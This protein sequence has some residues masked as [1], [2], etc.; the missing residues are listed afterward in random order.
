MPEPLEERAL[1]DRG[2]RLNSTGADREEWRSNGQ[3][4]VDRISYSTEF[5]RLAGVTQVIP[6]QQDHLYHDR[7]THSIK[8]AQVAATLARRLHH[9][10]KKLE[11][12]DSLSSWVDADHC[13]AAGLAHDIGH[14]PFGHAGENAL[15]QL[16]GELTGDA[17][18]EA[19]SRRSFEGNA[20]SMRI[21]ASLSFR[22]DE[23]QAGLD[24]TLRSLAAVA[25]YP[26]LRGGHPSAIP[27][28]AE[29]WSFYPEEAHVLERL[30]TDGYI[31]VEMGSPISGRK[32]A[33]IL[34][35][36]RWP[37]AEIM[38]WADDISYAVH[39]LE[40]FFRAGQI[41][42]HR[43]AAALK[44]A[45][46]H[47]DWTQTDFSFAGNDEEVAQALRFVRHK[48]SKV[49]VGS[50]AGSS[51]EFVAPAFN[52]IRQSLA[53]HFPLT[54]FDGTRR[55]QASVQKF[56]STIITYLTTACHLESIAVGDQQRVSFVISPVAQIVAEFFKAICHY[57][58]IGTSTVTT[59]QTGHA[60]N[61]GMMFS[62]L[63]KLSAEW[64]RHA[65][66]PAETRGLPARLREYIRATK[67]TEDA[68]AALL[69]LKVAV[70]DYICSLR[71]EQA[72]ALTA[73]FKGH[74]DHFGL[75]AA[76]LDT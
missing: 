26:W 11:G 76:W 49:P 15:Q 40:D 43:L 17:V 24:L 30:R 32:D 19:L 4:D 75:S 66:E 48:L 62:S 8:V 9:T 57:F 28:L 16:L 22:K 50:D 3:I 33:E 2:D 12:I 71:D 10:T 63:E 20:Q 21:V 46:E 5:R 70:V 56:G 23:K 72:T 34:R 54:R 55:S 36:H 13:Y 65:E 60:L 69:S 38:D 35:V 52:M 44:A 47:I 73:R 58:V 64:A 1:F 41:P 67:N 74:R 7:L 59:M 42:L 14:P 25:K 68:G 37:E 61:V 27:K 31:A 29:K 45:P 6:P 39:D 53:L 18:T 51:E